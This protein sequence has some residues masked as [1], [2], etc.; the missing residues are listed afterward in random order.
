LDDGSKVGA[1]GDY[2]KTKDARVIAAIK[3]IG[4]GESATAKFNVSKLSTTESYI[5]FC[6]FLGHAFMMKGVVNLI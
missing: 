5:F 6:S 3:I 4:G 1:A 2:V